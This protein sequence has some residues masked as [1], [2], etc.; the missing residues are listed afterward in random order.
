MVLV[1]AL[2]TVSG[3]QSGSPAFDVASVRKWS[4]TEGAGVPFM[5]ANGS[6]DRNRI[7]VAALVAFAFDLQDFQ[8]AGGPD[9]IRREAFSVHARTNQTASV[10]QMKLMVQ[11]LLRDRFGM[12]AHNDE[13]PM[14]SYTLTLARGDH[15]T[16]PGLKSTSD[17]A[18]RHEVPPLPGVPSGA[19]TAGGCGTMERFARMFL[20]PMLAAPVIDNTG[21]AGAYDWSFYHSR[22]GLA[23]FA[24]PAEPFANQPAS[25]PGVPSLQSAL[26]EQLGLKLDSARALV[27]VLVID[28]MSQP[29]AN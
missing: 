18:C 19:L 6:F 22:E 12:R 20:G 27:K 25:D 5:Q 13:R 10:A 29:T 14:P 7:T 2:G 17:P 24:N 1:F 11:R 23:V 21:L 15:R 3:A 16:G 4:T 9:W 8:I 26:R 28:A